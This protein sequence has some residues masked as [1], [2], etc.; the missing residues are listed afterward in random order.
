M[1]ST[2]I[3]EE[4]GN[5]VDMS[6]FEDILAIYNKTRKEKSDNQSTVRSYQVKS[7]SSG[8]KTNL[9]QQQDCKYDIQK[10]K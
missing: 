10:E 7:T 5:G 9:L 4:L 6:L 8:E 1:A 2:G 3:I